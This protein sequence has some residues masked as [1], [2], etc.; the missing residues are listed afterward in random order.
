M[1]ITILFTS[2]SRW[3]SDPQFVTVGEVVGKVQLSVLVVNL[4]SQRS[5]L[6]K[7]GA[8]SYFK[9]VFIVASNDGRRRHAKKHYES[10]LR[11]GNH[12]V[13]AFAKA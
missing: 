2:S 10:C 1:I 11:G 4:Q 7:R 3:I 9:I 8:S 12:H 6:A 5:C 13:A